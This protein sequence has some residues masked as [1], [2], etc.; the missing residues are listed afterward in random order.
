VASSW[1]VVTEPQPFDT[2]AHARQL[3]HQPNHVAHGPG[4]RQL[5]RQPREGDLGPQREE[6]LQGTRHCA[7]VARIA[8]RSSELSIVEALDGLRSKA[9][10]PPGE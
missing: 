1:A 7:S 8:A 9:S 2:E 10:P 6:Q 3:A 5:Q 4:P